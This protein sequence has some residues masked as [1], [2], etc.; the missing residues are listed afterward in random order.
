MSKLVTE[1]EG[2]LARE[3]NYTVMTPEDFDYRRR[4]NDRFLAGVMAAKQIVLIDDRRTNLKQAPAKLE[5]DIAEMAV[6]IDVKP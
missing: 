4:L 5:D 6:P 3:I 2:E 1:M